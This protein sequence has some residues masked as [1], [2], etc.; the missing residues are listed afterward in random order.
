MTTSVEKYT[1]VQ[2]TLKYL[3]IVD[4]S[5]F[6]PLNNYP[7]KDSFHF[8]HIRTHRRWID[9][10]MPY[11]VSINDLQDDYETNKCFN[12]RVSV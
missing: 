7:V 5:N 10:G 9:G 6:C 4:N 12:C 8:F 1:R 2:P 11:I 3:I